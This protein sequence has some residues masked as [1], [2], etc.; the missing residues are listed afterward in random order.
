M[1]EFES[2]I[3]FNV[4]EPDPNPDIVSNLLSRSWHV[5][6]EYLM[7]NFFLPFLSCDLSYLWTIYM[8]YEECF[9]EKNKY[10]FF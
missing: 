10:C 8:Q 6:V 4:T 5:R 3:S 9:G 2:T 1:K 7:L